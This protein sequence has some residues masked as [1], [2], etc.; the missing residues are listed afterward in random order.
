MDYKNLENILKDY[1][2]IKLKDK[3]IFY[4]KTNIVLN[5]TNNNFV[6]YAN[7]VDGQI[8]FKDYSQLFDSFKLEDFDIE[9]FINKTKPLFKN[10]MFIDSTSINYEVNELRFGLEI[11]DFIKIIILLE[12]KLNN[13]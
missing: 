2:F 8:I 10:H 3:E 13:D 7:I 12:T 4:L 6:I 5:G 1:S 9:Y 11:S